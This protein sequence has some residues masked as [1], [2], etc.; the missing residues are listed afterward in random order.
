MA[1][2]SLTQQDIRLFQGLNK[3]M[4]ELFEYRVVLNGIASVKV[5]KSPL[6]RRAAG[7]VWPSG[8]RRDAA[9]T[10]G[11]QARRW[12]SQGCGREVAGMGAKSRSFSDWL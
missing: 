9:L 12:I 11:A 6:F 10:D 3:V 4:A 1:P 5:Q 2:K 7:S 8:K